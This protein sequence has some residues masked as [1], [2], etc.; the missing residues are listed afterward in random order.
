M[1]DTGWTPMRVE[2]LKSLWRDGLSASQAAKRPW[3]A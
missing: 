1:S 3:A 2:T